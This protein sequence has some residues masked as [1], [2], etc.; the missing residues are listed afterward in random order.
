VSCRAKNEETTGSVSSSKTPTG[1]RDESPVLS[2]KCE[3]GVL[4]TMVATRERKIDTKG[5]R[6]NI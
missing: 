1:R 3:I 5:P 6:L 2:G 4:K